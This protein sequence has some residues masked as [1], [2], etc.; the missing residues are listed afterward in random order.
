MDHDVPNYFSYWGKVDLADNLLGEHYNYHLLPYH[1]IDV[2]TVGTTL[3]KINAGLKRSMLEIVS[4]EE[5]IF[6]GLVFLFLSTHDFG[7]FS[8]RFQN[9]RP[10][11]LYKLLHIRINQ[12]YSVRHDSLGLFAKLRIWHVTFSTDQFI[13]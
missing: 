11:L 10:E 2:A 8:Q 13:P 12:P 7:K 5:D 1:C 3:L 4:L 9:L 6:F